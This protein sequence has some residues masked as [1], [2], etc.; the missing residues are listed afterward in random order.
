[1]ALRA[2]TLLLLYVVVIVIAAASAP[3]S[4]AALGKHDR[5]VIRFFQH[6]PRQAATPEGGLALSRVLPKV[7][8]ELAAVTQ[9]PAHHQLWLCIHSHEASDWSNQDTGHNGHYGGLQMHP[10]WGYGTSWYASEDSELVQEN[11]AETGYRVNGYSTS[12]LLGQWYHTDCLAY[13]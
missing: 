13:A 9:W 3:D 4:S 2:Y 11:A 6:H 1:M 10:G 5:D 7:V 12:W 8:R